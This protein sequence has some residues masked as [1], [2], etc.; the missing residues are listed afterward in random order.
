MREKQGKQPNDLGEEK[1]EKGK[2]NKRAV[3]QEKEHPS[4]M[5]PEHSNITGSEAEQSVN[6]EGS[7]TDGLETMD[8]T[9]K[10]NSDSDEILRLKE[11]YR[12]FGIEGEEATMNEIMDQ[13]FYF[14]RT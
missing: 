3:T 14:F 10:A 4:H 1:C 11:A 7:I 5:K 13:A 12:R 9:D 2:E 8:V 6:S